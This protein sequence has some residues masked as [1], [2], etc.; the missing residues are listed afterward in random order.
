MSVRLTLPASLLLACAGIAVALSPAG[1]ADTIVTAVSAPAA[2]AAAAK[3]DAT[4]VDVRSPREWRRTGVATGART[5][6]IHN[7]GGIDAFV[8]EMVKTVGGDRSR[9]VALICATGG[10]SARAAKILA[11]AGFTNLQN[12]AEGMQGRPDSGPGWLRRGLPV[13]PCPEC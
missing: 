13:T 11:D 1:R 4:L 7:R 2:L 3:G 12:V 10:R 8:A 6:T 5:V 9:P